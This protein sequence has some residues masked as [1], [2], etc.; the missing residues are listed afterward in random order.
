MAPEI[1]AQ[2]AA[3]HSNHFNQIEFLHST[4]F[5]NASLRQNHQCARQTG[6]SARAITIGPRDNCLKAFDN[7]HVRRDKSRGL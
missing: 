5:W 6:V 1:I 7:C 2:S 3:P 4:G